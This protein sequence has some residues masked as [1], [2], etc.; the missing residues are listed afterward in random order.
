MNPL[1]KLSELTPGDCI[2]HHVFGPLSLLRKQGSVY[3]FASESDGG[4]M[5]ELH[6]TGLNFKSITKTNFMSKLKEGNGTAS[7]AEAKEEKAAKPAKKAKASKPA[8]KK[9]KVEGT[10]KSLTPAEIKTALKTSIV[11]NAN[12]FYFSDLNVKDRKEGKKIAVFVTPRA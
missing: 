5:I 1:T 2:K 7:A 10:A 4:G 12:G 8:A 11:R 3:Y 9:V 6:D